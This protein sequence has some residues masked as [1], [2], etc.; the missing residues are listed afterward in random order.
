MWQRVQTLY[1]AV[2]LGLLVAMFWHLDFLW[3]TILLG[4]AVFMQTVAL[5]AYKFRLFQMR[6]AVIAAI[7]LIGLQA[8][9][10]VVFFVR[11]GAA[12]NIT[13]VF[14][15]VAAI[16]DFLAARAILSDE[17]VVRSSSR[18]RASKRKR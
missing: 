11:G 7:M 17:M 3:W 12:F 4:V 6:T 8:W 14:P 15:A 5:L 10:A 16:L 13:A 2:A 9:M 18:L 1:L